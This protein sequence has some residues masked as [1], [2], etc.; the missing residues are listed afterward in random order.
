MAAFRERHP[1]RDGVGHADRSRFDNAFSLDTESRSVRLSIADRRH[2]YSY[3]YPNSDT[4]RHSYSHTYRDTNCH[5]DSNRNGNTHA[6]ADSNP[7][8]W[9]NAQTQADTATALIA[10]QLTKHK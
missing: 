7:E 10:G 9:S 5:C 8:A 3:A 2:S 1:T 4:Y 6:Q